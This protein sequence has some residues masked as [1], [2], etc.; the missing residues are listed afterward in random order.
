MRVKGDVMQ[1]IDE[2]ALPRT[3]DDL[4][5]R[6]LRP[7]QKPEVKTLEAGSAES[8]GSVLPDT[9]VNES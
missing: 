8:S 1:P 7:W 5:S 4:S 9:G 6:Q 3:A 2:N